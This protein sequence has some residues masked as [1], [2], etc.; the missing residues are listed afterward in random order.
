VSEV[1]R[2]DAVKGSARSSDA[3]PAFVLAIVQDASLTA[4]VAMRRVTAARGKPSD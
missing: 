4:S 2:G 3:T 1:A